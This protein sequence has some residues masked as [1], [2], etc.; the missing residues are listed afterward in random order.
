MLLKNDFNNFHRLKI[1]KL[2]LYILYLPAGRHV[3][4]RTVRTSAFRARHY[5]IRMPV[6][7]R[8]ITD[9]ALNSEQLMRSFRLAA[10]A[11]MQQSLSAVSVS[12]P[13]TMTF[14][15]PISYIYE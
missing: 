14:F 12:V 11:D 3:V 2:M 4:V 13:I 8:S 9:R 10:G 6:N 5:F 7:K 1:K 15:K